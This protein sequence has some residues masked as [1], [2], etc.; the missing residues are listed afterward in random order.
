MNGILKT[1][2]LFVCFAAFA[3]HARAADIFSYR[4]SWYISGGVTVAGAAEE[5]G[6]ADENKEGISQSQILLKLSPSIEQFLVD[7]LSI[8]G[9][10]DLAWERL[11]VENGRTE[12]QLTWDIVA[13]PAFYTP[14]WTNVYPYLWPYGGFGLSKDYKSV[15]EDASTSEHQFI[16]GVEP[17]L[18]MV[19]GNIVARLGVGYRRLFIRGI[20]IEIDGDSI[21]QD[22]QDWNRFYFTVGIGTYF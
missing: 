8:R 22:S 21:D 1:I 9:A 18:A 16:I 2:A 5:I 14:F 10:T 13:G 17:G 6:F 19:T 11:S 4:G 15:G 3:S 20:K 7:G 12:N